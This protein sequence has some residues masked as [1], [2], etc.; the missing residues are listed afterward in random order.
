M[1]KKKVF[2]MYFSIAIQELFL[3]FNVVIQ[4][5]HKK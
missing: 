1:D 3:I 4:I 5:I 2:K